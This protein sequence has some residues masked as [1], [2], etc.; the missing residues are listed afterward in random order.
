MSNFRFN[1]CENFETNEFKFNFVYDER[2]AFN[3]SVSIDPEHVNN[4]LGAFLFECEN[5]ALI[6]NDSWFC[7]FFHVHIL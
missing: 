7:F 5:A 1:D 3:V 6:I 2:I 4:D